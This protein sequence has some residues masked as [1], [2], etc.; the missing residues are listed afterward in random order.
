MTFVSRLASGVV[1]VLACSTVIAQT[2]PTTLPAS[3]VIGIQEAML[4][5]DYWVAK[6]SSPN[7]V[8]LSKAQI[9][10]QNAQLFKTDTSTY[11]LAKIGPALTRAQIQG[12]IEHVSKLD[13]KPLYDEHDQPI[14]RST[15]DAV[16][17][18]I[19]LDQVPAVSQARY[20][21]VV[22]RVSLRNFPTSLRA[23]PGK[24]LQDFERFQESTL[25]PG[26]PVAIVH[27]SL[28]GQWFFVVS[29]RY[30][31]WVERSAI[32]V[33]SRDE[34]LAYA[35][36]TPSRVITG[37]KVRTVYTPEAPAVSELQLDMGLR[38]PLDNLPP[39]QPVNGQG[40]YEAWTL[41][42]PV[43]ADDGSLRFQP[44]LLQRTLDSSQDYLP[45]TQANIV[46]Q[47][48]KFL[49]E[50]Y[51]WGH[52]YNGRD[53]SGFVSDVYRSMGVQMPRNTGDQSISPALHHR[54][55]TAADNHATRMQAIAQ[56][57]TG[58]LIY[59]PG[60]V[61]MFLGRVDGQPYVIQDVGGLVFHD[62]SGKLRWTKTNEVS[63]TP[64]LPLLVSDKLSYVD[65]ITSIVHIR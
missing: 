19:A 26:D 34:V 14:P 8:I 16:V 57:Q 55:F 53:C 13:D 28:D 6:L 27:T 5:P 25:F 12:W 2:A 4:S 37:D 65:A 40:P 35:A 48:F 43:R 63:V 17:A 62:A 42:L 23:F 11:D 9:D 7:Q 33:G 51:G 31:A 39:D 30:A 36:Q 1:T 41:K 44:A 3:G 47:A 58:D 32:A 21:L 59:I 61:M 60:H 56:A 18:G 64:L 29:P 45:L 15:I 52:L 54:V 20:G 49:G 46:R 22:H 50:R 38:I 24:G 10:A